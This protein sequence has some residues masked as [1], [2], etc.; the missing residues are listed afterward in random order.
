MPAGGAGGATAGGTGGWAVP[1]R[2]LPARPDRVR[3]DQWQLDALRAATAWQHARGRGVV[4]GVLDSGV[5]ATHKDLVGQVLPGLD[6][7]AGSGDGRRDPVGHGTTVA[8][9][10]AGR[11]DDETGVV[12]LAPEARILPVRVLD[13]DNRYEDAM[14]IAKGVRWAVD[15]GAR[16]I[17]LSLGGVG[18]SAALAE[19]LDYA[20]AKDV[21]VI[22]CTG[23]VTQSTPSDVWYP[24]REPGVVAVSGLDRTEAGRLWANSVTGR[25]TVLSAPATGL[26]GARPGGYWRVQGTSFAAPLVTA[27]AAL[28]RSRWPTLS[29]ANVVNRLVRTARDVGPPGRDASFGFGAVDPVAALTRSLPPVEAN[30]LDTAPPPGHAGFG[31]APGVA[32][33]PAGGRL[34]GRPLSGAPHHAGGGAESLARDDPPADSGAG[35]LGGV[36]IVVVLVTGGVLAVRRLDRSAP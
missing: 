16:V 31:A 8:G 1:G 29:A 28:I 27:T 26:V 12:G 7:V 11:G 9:L 5:D 10:I 24:A 14:V 21:V 6:L 18:E 2:A 19:A 35:L 30:P 17:N 36:A 20:F 34:T 15:R 22:A 13:V 33:V 3:T 23:N 25:A 32:E 4:V